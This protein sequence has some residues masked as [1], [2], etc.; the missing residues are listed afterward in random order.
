MY[1]YMCVCVLE[2]HLIS[3]F[4]QKVAFPELANFTDLIRYACINFR[5][6]LFFFLQSKHP[7]S[8]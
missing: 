6:K 5:V 4:I 8:S 7:A 1:I 3:Y 2:F